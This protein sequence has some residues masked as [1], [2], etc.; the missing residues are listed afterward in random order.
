M[1][2]EKFTFINDFTAAGYGISTLEDDESKPVQES[3]NAKLQ[4]G[5]KSVK[6]VLGPGTGMGQGILIK[7]DADGLYEPFPTEGGH[8]DFTVQ[9]QEDWDLV[10]FARKFIE[11]SD[12]VENKR[13]KATVGRMS[14][15][16]LGAGPAVPLLYAF[17]KEKHP[18]LETV[19]EKSGKAFEDIE[20]KDII[21]QAM[22]HKDPLCLKVVEKFAEIF[23]NETG[24]MALKT[25]PYG[26]IY[27]IGGVTNGIRGHLL[28]E[29][30]FLQA[31][32]NKGRLSPVMD[33]FQI[34]VVDSQIEIGMR[35]C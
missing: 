23:G 19:I 32:K 28:S 26:G 18:E 27:L 8:V 13:A 24:N 21:I 10:C 35:G 9:T 31:F 4:E 1:G 15:E 33:S 25:L 20:S 14:L 6:L 3:G 22:Q 16:R 17:M 11:T 34:R 2:F 7:M 29:K 12:N 30:T 5:A